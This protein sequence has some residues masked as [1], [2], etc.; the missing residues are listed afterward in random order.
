MTHSL[1]MSRI[2]FLNFVNFYGNFRGFLVNVSTKPSNFEVQE[3]RRKVISP[4]F[5]PHSA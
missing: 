3:R 1:G 2:D 4:C 5:V